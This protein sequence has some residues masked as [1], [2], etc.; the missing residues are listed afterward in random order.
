MRLSASVLAIAGLVLLAPGA[1]QALDLSSA[2]KNCEG[3]DPDLRQ[4]ETPDL[5]NLRFQAGG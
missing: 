4:S 3:N 5:V 2:V 1:A